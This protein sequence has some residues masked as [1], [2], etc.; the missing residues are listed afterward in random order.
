MQGGGKMSRKTVA[1]LFASCALALGSTLAAQTVC[2]GSIVG[3][4]TD[5]SKSALPGVTVTVTSPALQVSQIVQ[6][7]DARGQY[8]IKDLPPGT[9]QLVFE[10]TG[11]AKVIRPDVQ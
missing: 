4:I 7:S 9:Y 6:I 11:F 8:E 1:C 2:T 3:T 10:L 5:E